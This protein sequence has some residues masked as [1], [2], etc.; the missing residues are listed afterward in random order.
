MITMTIKDVENLTGIPRASIRFYEKESLLCPHRE[1]NGYRIY[2]ESDIQQLQ[3]LK[4]LR[5][6]GLTLDEIRKAMNGTTSLCALLEDRRNCIIE[7]SDFL[8][9]ADRVCCQMCKEEVEFSTLDAPRYLQEL[10]EVPLP[11]TDILSKVQAPWTRYFAR[12]TDGWICTLLV[13]ILLSPFFNILDTRSPMQLIKFLMGLML[14]MLLEPLLLHFFGTT[15]GKWIFGLSV[16]S[17]EGGRLSLRHAFQRTFQVINSGCGFRLPFWSLYRYYKSYKTCKA[18]E[19]L[20]W[21]EYSILILKPGKIRTAVFFPVTLLLIFIG[22]ACLTYN[23]EVPD[24]RGNMT[25]EQF[26]HNYNQMVTT[27]AMDETQKLS[28][29][30]LWLFPSYDSYGNSLEDFTHGDKPNFQYVLDRGIITEI[31]LDLHSDKSHWIPDLI[32]ERILAARAFV[33]AQQ[34]LFAFRD[35]TPVLLQKIQDDPFGNWMLNIN[36]VLVSN[37]V[38]L[39]G[40]DSVS[41]IGMLVP[42]K[43][44]SPYLSMHFSME[45]LDNSPKLK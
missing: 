29:N 7:E 45:I 12:F 5:T 9:N 8:H 16:T 6:L 2:E 19:A 30:G 3:R 10:Q 13:D 11:K 24:F 25:V 15:P 42:M 14:S 23:Q 35:E 28:L 33:R 39:R 40:Y 1:D 44:I 32:Q 38:V 18:G 27:F 37:E 34:P 36:G 43:N 21:E 22:G 4:L 20:P 26:S 17:M 41:T 31:V